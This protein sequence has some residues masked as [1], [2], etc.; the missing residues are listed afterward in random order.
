MGKSVFDFW[1]SCAFIQFR[2]ENG[3]RKGN[4]KEKDLGEEKERKKKWKKT[5]KRRCT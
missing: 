1:D 3:K 2:V 5:E 4:K